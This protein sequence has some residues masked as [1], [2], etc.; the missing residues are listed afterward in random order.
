L[1][2]ARDSLGLQEKH[3]DTKSK[4]KVAPEIHGTTNKMAGLHQYKD[5][6]DKKSCDAKKQQETHFPAR[7]L[8]DRSIVEFDV[9]CR[10]KQRDQK[11]DEC[12]HHDTYS[13]SADQHDVNDW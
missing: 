6:Q 4:G 10:D 8:H 7:R 3:R 13:C 1:E 2:H 9:D 12:H 11:A 5:S